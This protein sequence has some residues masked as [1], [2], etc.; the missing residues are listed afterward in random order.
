[1]H[2]DDPYRRAPA[3]AAGAVSDPYSDE[4]RRGPEGRRGWLIVVAAILGLSALFSA[5]GLGLIAFE[6]AQGSYA[7]AWIE[8]TL[9]R[10]IADATL[11]AL[12]IAALALFWRKSP[13]FVPAFATWAVAATVAKS[14]PLMLLVPT[15]DVSLLMALAAPLAWGVC[16]YGP[17][18]VYVLRSRRVRN[19]FAARD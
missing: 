1:M 3:S 6:Y 2:E 12:A 9:A 11:L 15:G 10:A 8:H 18:I 4:R 13:W 16:W 5:V 19:T 14:V 7:P 17:W